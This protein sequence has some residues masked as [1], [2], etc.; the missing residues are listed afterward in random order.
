MLHQQKDTEVI[1]EFKPK[2]QEFYKFYE[3]AFPSGI[4]KH[5][6]EYSNIFSHKYGEYYEELDGIARKLKIRTND[7]MIILY[8][9]ELYAACTTVIYRTNKN[10]LLMGRNTDYNFANL[11]GDLIYKAKYLRGGKHLYTCQDFTGNILP[12]HCLK[13]HKFSTALIPGHLLGGIRIQ[14]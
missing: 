11:L 14:G 7:Y 6:N 8:I 5:L 2:I 13:P 9:Y 3:N 4:K 10:E 1:K 12:S